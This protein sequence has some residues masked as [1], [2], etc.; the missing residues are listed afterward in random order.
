MLSQRHDEEAK[1]ST[2]I[3]CLSSR[4]RFAKPEECVTEISKPSAT[5]SITLHYCSISNVNIADSGLHGRNMFVRGPDLYDHFFL[6]LVT[7][8]SIFA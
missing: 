3:G 8:L 2:D 1:T 5:T 6:P 7:M 4:A